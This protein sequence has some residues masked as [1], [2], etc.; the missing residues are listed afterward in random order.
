[1]HQTVQCAPDSVRCPSCSA[2]ELMALGN[3]LGAAAKIH[4]AVQ[5]APYCPVSQQRPRQ[6][7][8]AQSAGDAWPEPT[9]S[10]RTGQCPVRQEVQGATV[11]FAKKG[12][13]LGT[14][15]ALF[16]SGGAPDCPVRHPTEGMNCLPNEASTAPRP[17]GTIKGTPKR[18]QQKRAANKSIHHWDQF[19]LS[20]SC[21]SI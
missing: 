17:F 8:A 14:G 20:L 10:W 11:G 7:S 13:R 21:V 18:L 5:C 3:R 2:G 1:V 19:F 12:R 4:R 6:R 9:V 16:M 15:Q